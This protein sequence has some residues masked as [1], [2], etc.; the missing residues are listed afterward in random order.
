MCSDPRQFYQNASGVEIASRMELQ[1]LVVRRVNEKTDRY[2]F[3]LRFFGH[4]MI[5]VSG[6]LATCYVAPNTALKFYGVKGC[7]ATVASLFAVLTYAVNENM[8]SYAAAE[9]V[10]W[11]PVWTAFCS[12]VQGRKEASYGHLYTKP[13]NKENAEWMALV[14]HSS[15][16]FDNAP[17]RPTRCVNKEDWVALRTIEFL[18]D[19][20]EKTHYWVE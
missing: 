1:E 15:E 13:M 8:R 11:R 18:L 19:E 9:G 16:A 4:P 7:C 17:V 12:L 20:G 10:F 14:A 2:A 3:W 6:L 5:M